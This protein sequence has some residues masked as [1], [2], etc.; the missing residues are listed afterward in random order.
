MRSN[1]PV[2]VVE[3]E[4]DSVFLL[5]RAFRKADVKNAI[6]SVAN[7]ALAIDYLAQA[8]VATDRT[9]FPMPAMVL[10]DLKLPRKSGFEVLQ[11]IRAHPHLRSMI[12]VV[13]TSSTARGDISKAYD[14]GANSYLVKP[15]S[16]II[17]TELAQE[18]SNYWLR[19]NEPPI[20]E[21]S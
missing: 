6:R 18:L 3:D 8:A 5:E 17:L 15:A 2:L 12:V 9:T 16:L 4:E 7:G 11:W 13:F 1:P 19:R 21:A 20:E 10:L 14:A